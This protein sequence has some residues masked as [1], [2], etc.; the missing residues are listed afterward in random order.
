MFPILDDVVKGDDVATK[1]SGK[2]AA[3]YVNWSTPS[4]ITP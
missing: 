1:G 4:W 3:S 2:F